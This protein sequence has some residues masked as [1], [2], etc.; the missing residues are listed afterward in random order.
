MAGIVQARRGGAHRSIGMRCG[1]PPRRPEG[2]VER[3]SAARFRSRLAQGQ[4]VP[5]SVSADTTTRAS[6]SARPDSALPGTMRST[7]YAKKIVDGPVIPHRSP[8]ASG[9]L[10]RLVEVR[11]V[12][13]QAKPYARRAPCV[14][15]AGI[16]KTLDKMCRGGLPA[17]P[18]DK[19]VVETGNGNRCS[20]CS[21]TIDP[22]EQ[23]YF[24][25]IRGVGSFR[26]HD[27]R[28]N[29]WATFKT[30]Y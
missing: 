15:K 18:K 28:C 22:I 25:V 11:I 13:A 24:I 16:D 19:P 4:Q 14:S 26:F 17:P 7:F 27:I 1:S 30:E 12:D 20:S 5:K 10:D 23:M 2:C 3:E 6:K 21:E 29:A 8:R 9:A